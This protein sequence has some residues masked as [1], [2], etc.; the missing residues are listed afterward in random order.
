M[1]LNI[2]LPVTN[3]RVGF[4]K[5]VVTLDQD[6]FVGALL[7][8]DRIGKPMEF[9]VTYPVKPSLV[10][11]TIYGASLIPH[12]GV[13]LCGRPLYEMLE[14]KPSLLLVENEQFL[15]LNET[16]AGIVARIR[17]PEQLTELVQEDSEETLAHPTSRFQPLAITWPSN[18]D[19]NVRLR[20][21]QFLEKLFEGMDLIEPFERIERAVKVLAKE[22]QRFQ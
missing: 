5:L 6:G 3:E 8:T 17:R 11:R 18:Y 15:P 20:A 16:V 4:F 12:I 7:V 19:R 22:D 1:G 2:E 14:T 13:E 21:R 10:Q 9:R